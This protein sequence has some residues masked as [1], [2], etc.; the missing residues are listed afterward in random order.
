MVTE[1]RRVVAKQC[2]EKRHH[3]WCLQTVDKP[4]LGIFAKIGFSHLFEKIAAIFPQ[5]AAT[6]VPCAFFHFHI[7][8]FFKFIAAYLS[9][10]HF[11]TWAKPLYGV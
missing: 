3:M 5:I 2:I 10:T 4:Y 6:G 7:A 11:V 8:N 9:F 1:E